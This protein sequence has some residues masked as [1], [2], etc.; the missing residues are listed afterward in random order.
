MYHSIDSLH[1]VLGF[2]TD[3]EFIKKST[4]RSII[5]QTKKYIYHSVKNIAHITVDQ[6]FLTDF[7]F[8]VSMLDFTNHKTYIILHFDRHTFKESCLSGFF[9]Y[10]LL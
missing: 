4:M 3:Y 9:Y 10:E 6:N 7:I 8:C 1:K 5:K 2:R